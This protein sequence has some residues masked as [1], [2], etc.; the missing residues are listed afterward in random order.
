MIYY[1]FFKLKKGWV[2]IYLIIYI[3]FVVVKRNKTISNQ[4]EK[5]P[6]FKKKIIMKFSVDFSLKIIFNATE[7]L[8]RSNQLVE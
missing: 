3:P 5:D 4:T 8:I 6:A 2:N 1:D 7:K